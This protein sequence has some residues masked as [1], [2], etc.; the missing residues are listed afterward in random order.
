MASIPESLGFFNSTYSYPEDGLYNQ[1]AHFLQHLQQCLHLYCESDLLDRLIT[2]LNDSVSKWFDDQ[3]EFTSLHD[4]DIALTKAFPSSESTTIQSAKSP[5]QGQEKLKASK[6]QK[7]VE[8]Q[9]LKNAKRVKS[10]ILKLEQAAKSTSGLQDIGIFD[11]TLTC[12]DR[13][14]DEATNFLQHLQQCQH[15]YRESDLLFLLSSCLYG[16]AFDIWYDKQSIMNSA[17]LCEWIEILR[18]DFAAAAFAKSKVNCSKIICMRCDSSFNSKEKLR[19]H[20]RE[21]HAKKLISSSSLSINTLKSVCKDEEKPIFDDSSASP[22]PQESEISTATPKQ[23]SESTMIFGAIT[24]SKVSH[25][26][27]SASETVRES[28]KNTSTQCSST[29]SRSSPSQTFESEHQE[30]SV[31]KSSEFCSSLSIDTAKSV[32]EIEKR[33]AVIET[34][35]LQA[36]HIPFT[37]SRSQVAFETTSSK[38]SSLPTEAPKVV[39]ESVEN[40]SNQE[41]TCASVIC[42]LCKQNFNS[43]KELYEHIRN[44]EDLELA[45][46]SHLS[47]NALDLVCEIE[48]TSFALHKTSAQKSQEIDVQKSSI[49][50]S[51]LLIDTVKSACGAKEKSAVN[52]SIALP[53]AFAISRSQIL[54][55]AISLQS[56]SSKYSNLSIT[57]LKITSECTESKSDSPIEIAEAAEV[58]A[59]SIA[60]IRAQAARIRARRE[61]ECSDLQLRALN[62]TPKS[63]ESTSI[64]QIACARAFCKRCKQSFNFNNKLHE[65]I[66]QHHARKPVKSSDLRALASGFTYKI[67]EKSAVTCPPAPHASSIS[68]ATPRSQISS[69]ELDSRSVPS[70]DSH[71]TIATH[72][73]AP[74]LAESASATCPLTSS[75]SS[76][77]ISVRKHQ[78]SNT[79]KSYLTMDD[80]SRMFAEKPK[81]FDLPQHQNRSSSPQNF[82]ICQPTS[83]KKSYLIIENLFKMFGERFRRKSIFQDQKNVSSRGFSSEQLRITAYFKPTA[84]QKLS[85]SQDSESSKSKSL[86][87]HMPAEFIRT[88]FSKCSEKSAFLSYKMSDIFY[89]KP[90]VFLQ[91]RSSSRFS[92]TWSSLTSSPSSRSSSSDLHSCCICFGQFSSN[93]WLHKHLRA[94]HQGHS[95]CQSMRVLN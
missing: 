56:D 40:E 27:S 81:P 29:S 44:H 14:F 60:D 53:A 10:K 92:F 23:I 74:E 47:I 28:M 52:D 80:L 4:F 2:V 95:S 87:Q 34:S 30:I 20:V 51:L 65:H 90:K 38:G 35:A 79:Q 72:R 82:D 32:C 94:S 69:A 68:S 36:P 48:E 37:T 49:V 61:A 62:S 50:N 9:A 93:N 54:D 15:Q 17:S 45:K 31:Q 24:A 71:L 1:I 46:D 84:N 25:L 63:L 8:R 57:T 12:E 85:I 73:I 59:K 55:T 21:Q 66:R 41:V 64:Q 39:S 18:I 83:S 42:K 13:R 86:D 7:R 75:S 70:R 89:T 19:E 6:E 91:S 16:S 76:S 67:A 78:E 3:S 33:S 22:T 77:W 88:N 5:L 58:T 43:N 26:P 11:S